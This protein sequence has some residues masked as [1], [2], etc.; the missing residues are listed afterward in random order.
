MPDLHNL[1]QT[2]LSLSLILAQL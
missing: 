2:P 1:V